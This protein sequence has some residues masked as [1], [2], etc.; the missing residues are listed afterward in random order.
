MVTQNFRVECRFCH[1]VF[2]VRLMYGYTKQPFEFICKNCKS[3]IYG[4]INLEKDEFEI[5]NALYRND[6]DIFD[7]K[8]I[9]FNIE[10]IDS[11][12][13]IKPKDEIEAKLSP[14]MRS[15]PYF[16]DNFEILSCKISLFYSMYNELYPKINRLNRFF[17][18]QDFESI[19]KE[20]LNL[21]SVGTDFEIY[22][23]IIQ[24]N[25][26]FLSCLF[27]NELYELN[28][29]TLQNIFVD[30]CDVNTS[31]V[32]NLAENLFNVDF[33]NF[34]YEK[35]ITY[36]KNVLENIYYIQPIISTQYLKDT[37]QL[38]I[39]IT[40]KKFEYLKNVYT[41]GIGIANQFLEILLSLIAIKKGFSFNQIPTSAK[42]KK[43]KTLDEI[44][45]EHDFNKK[46]ILLNL[47]PSFN[48]CLDFALDIRLRNGIA[49]PRSK[50]NPDSNMIEYYPL[51][52]GLQRSTK[53]EM[54]YIDFVRKLYNIF[55]IVNALFS[56]SINLLS[57]YYNKIGVQSSGIGFLS[58]SYRK[59]VPKLEIELFWNRYDFDNFTIFKN[60]SKYYEFSR[61]LMY[62]EYAKLKYNNGKYTLIA[63]NYKND[64]N[65]MESKKRNKE[66]TK[67]VTKNKKLKVKISINVPYIKFFTLK[68]P[69]I[70]TSVGQ[71]F[72]CNE[73]KFDEQQQC[74]IKVLEIESTILVDESQNILLRIPEIKI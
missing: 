29:E 40:N 51:K 50:F 53:C 9:D 16:G 22:Q 11:F 17:I 74:L 63:G 28:K 45:K 18:N 12:P 35:V 20:A 52:E 57:M 59:K 58:I 71:M 37:S 43:F 1:K 38:E 44:S 60:Y 65:F 62:L 39:E 33:F 54:T 7:D 42:M 10:L 5:Q 55:V 34:F 14:F 8:K 49:H 67:C 30:S 32:E 23:G 21:F 66:F 26:L 2:N 48:K 27:K 73:W 13:L 61:D 69:P 36:N 41:D 24:I 47:E 15:I 25:E 46:T 3:E 31:E 70:A 56:F 72:N 64:L 68:Q 19:K 4:S 6:I